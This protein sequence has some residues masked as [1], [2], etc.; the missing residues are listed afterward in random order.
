MCV[1]VLNAAS[2]CSVRA[3]CKGGGVRWEGWRDGPPFS[4]PVQDHGGQVRLS[5][6][7]LSQSN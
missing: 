3:G 1:C 7:S 6:L 4:Q 2:E 5:S